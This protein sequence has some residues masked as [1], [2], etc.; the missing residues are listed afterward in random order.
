ME[1][2]KGIEPSCAVW[3]TAVLPLNYARNRLSEDIARL[4][5]VNPRWKQ[6]AATNERMTNG[7]G[8]LTAKITEDTKDW[9]R[10]WTLMGTGCYGFWMSKRARLFWRLLRGVCAAAGLRHS[11]RPFKVCLRQSSAWQAGEKHPSTNV[12]A[13]NN[14][15]AKLSEWECRGC[16]IKT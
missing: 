5:L 14:R 11:R 15:E 16:R 4:Q 6:M 13:S 10:R 9:S 12:Q 7:A 3:K 1:R 2:A 8:I